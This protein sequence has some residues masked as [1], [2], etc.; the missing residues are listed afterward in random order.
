MKARPRFV[1]NKVLNDLDH[2][3]AGS[4][5]RVAL[6]LGLYDVF[7]DQNEVTDLGEEYH[8]DAMLVSSFQGY[9]TQNALNIGDNGNPLG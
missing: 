7:S 5:Y 2:F 8:R 1:L 6:S 9:M 4:L 3:R